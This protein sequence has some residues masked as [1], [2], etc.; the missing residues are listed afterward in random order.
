MITLKQLKATNFKGLHSVDVTFPERGSIL[1]EGHNEAGKSTLFE[2]VYVALYGKPLVG[3]DSRANQNEV[4]HHTQTRATVQ[5]TF[6]VG[7][8]ELT[9]LRSFER[10]KAQQV[11]LTIQRPDEPPEV[12]SRSRPVEE[13]I[14]KELGNLDGD[15][16]R[17]SC[18]VEQKELGRIETLSFAQREQAIQKLLGLERLTKLTD[19]FKFKREQERELATAEKRLNLAQTQ[20]DVRKET[21]REAELAECLDAI[22]V[23]NELQYLTLL[24]TQKAQAEQDLHACDARIHKI[25]ERLERCDEL[26][27]QVRHGEQ[28]RQQLAEAHRACDA[29]NQKANELARLDDIEQK[30]L[31]A[32]RMHLSNVQT[33]VEAVALLD[34]AKNDV[35]R[36]EEA[37]REAQRQCR[38]LEQA[39]KEQ[40][41]TTVEVT[42]A[43][44]RISQRQKEAEAAQQRL[45][46]QAQELSSRKKALEET[47][48]QVTQWENALATLRST[49]QAIDEAEQQV[50]ELTRLQADMHQDEEAVRKLEAEVSQTEQEKLAATEKAQLAAAWDALANWLRLKQVEMSLTGFADQYKTLTAGQQEAEKGLATVRGKLRV[51]L[52]AGIGLSVL[53]VLALV[54]GLFWPLAFVLALLAAC[55]AVMSWLWFSRAR[56]IVRQAA[57]QVAGVHTD[58][59]RLEMQRQASMQVNGDPAMLRQ[60]EQQLQAANIAVP[61]DLAA[62]NILKEHLQ[63]KGGSTLDY[64][65]LQTAAQQAGNDHTRL[66][67]QLRQARSALTTGKTALHSVQ[68]VGNPAERLRTFHVQK[69]EQEQAIAKL[70]QHSRATLPTGVTW[71]PSS[72]SLQMLLAS[73]RAEIN[74]NQTAQKQQQGDAARLLQE[75]E[76]DCAK[77]ES[78]LQH[79]RVKADALRVADPLAKLTT[80]QDHLT[81]ARASQQQRQAELTPL[82]LRIHV[83]FERDVASEQGRVQEQIQAHER[84][85]ESRTLLQA[86]YS[87]RKE[88]FIKSLTATWTQA[89]DLLTA[90]HRLV[91]TD[92]PSLP[93]KTITVENFPS[94]EGAIISV[95]DVT[96]RAFTVMLSQLNEPQTKKEQTE[97]YNEQGRIKEQ[98]KGVDAEMQQR[99]R[100]ITGIL[101]ARTIATPTSYTRTALAE[102]WSLILS[103]SSSEERQVIAELGQIR[104]RLYAAQQQQQRL[105]NELQHPGTPLDIEE[106]QQKVDELREER[107]ICRLATQLLKETHDRIA[108]RVLPV[109]ERNMQPLLQQLTSG[110]YRDVRLTPEE[111]NGQPGEMDYRIRVWDPT[112]GRFVAK[113]LFSGGTRDQCSLALRL[114]FALATLPQ[115]LGVA[116]GFIFLD[117]PLSA[118]DAQRAQALVEL[119]TTGTIAQHFNQVVLISH[120]HAFDREAFQYHILMEAGQIVES[121]L[122]VAEDDYHEPAQFLPVSA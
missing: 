57:Q 100:T 108:R 30:Q 16:L 81:A 27:E 78:T 119:L 59:Q 67:E 55:G 21:A 85:L 122:P 93:Q 46:R 107:D 10:G 101:T 70:G 109:T 71:P 75:A 28:A 37:L 31:P 9:V 99:Q 63:Q 52:L 41:R 97:G 34:Q 17:N 121:D 86:E 23:V 62:G 38:A 111:S 35:V 47:L 90:V 44:A 74:A 103:V 83:R 106:C 5:L 42:Q 48:T 20:A 104:N 60:Y 114:A 1:I 69:S 53:T 80:A 49:Q 95:I 19:Q 15:S 50:Q 22:R 25:N 40:Q 113:N 68:Q 7:T 87:A 13:R 89:E 24:E 43:Q 29:L 39:E 45:A 66:V 12:I 72:Q 4:I 102:G 32:A 2:A 73:C 116:P 91:A 77:A 82:L 112:A 51:P 88:A 117:E 8:Q 18:F 79:A 61:A 110:R 65:T 56:R 105:T 92:A 94:I 58:I 33:A 98:K 96:K 54:M 26:K 64:H 120:Q 6:M 115:E 84:Q 76:A 36:A 14:L 118:F 3:E 11:T